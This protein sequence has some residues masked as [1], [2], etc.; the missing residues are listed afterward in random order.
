MKGRAIVGWI[1]VAIALTARYGPSPS[2][3]QMILTKD[4]GGFQFFVDELPDGRHF[5][6]ARLAGDWL[7]LE[8]Q[9][10][11]GILSEKDWQ[12]LNSLQRLSILPKDGSPQLEEP[13][14]QWGTMQ[15][16]GET[17]VLRYAE[18]WQLGRTPV[19]DSFLSMVYKQKA[20]I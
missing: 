13:G 18:W 3:H 19:C 14:E 2:S 4:G 11:S 20:S 8:P 17:I 10:E 7:V 1:V 16:R 15:R 9:K 6:E 5:Y 12:T